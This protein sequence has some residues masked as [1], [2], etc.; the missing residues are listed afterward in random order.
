[1]NAQSKKTIKERI[2]NLAKQGLRTLAFAVKTEGV[3]NILSSQ[4]QQ[5]LK[6][7]KNYP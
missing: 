1:L 3:E 6:D 5:L 7:P 4:G 2:S